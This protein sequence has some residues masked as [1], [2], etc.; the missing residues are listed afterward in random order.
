VARCKPQRPGHKEW[1]KRHGGSD[2]FVSPTRGY[3]LPGTAKELGHQAI[4]ANL[5]HKRVLIDFGAPCGASRTRAGRTARHAATG[6]PNGS[7]DPVRGEIHAL[8]TVA[9]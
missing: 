5:R 9:P 8:R 6:P 1:I 3:H 2:D 7:F 4:E